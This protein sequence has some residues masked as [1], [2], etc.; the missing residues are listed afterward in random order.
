MVQAVKITTLKKPFK[1]FWLDTVDPPPPAPLFVP[2]PPHILLVNYYVD[3]GMG[4]N[5]L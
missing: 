4:V 3:H 2:Q 1:S 5:G